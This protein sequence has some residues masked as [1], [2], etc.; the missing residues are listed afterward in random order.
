[1]RIEALEYDKPPTKNKDGKEISQDKQD[2]TKYIFVASVNWKE[3]GKNENGNSSSDNEKKDFF[4]LKG[5]ILGIS[6]G[7][8]DSENGENKAVQK[9]FQSALQAMNV[10]ALPPSVDVE[11]K[12]LEAEANNESEKLD[13]SAK[14]GPDSESNNGESSST[15]EPEEEKTT[16]K[17]E[18]E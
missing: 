15:S 12:Q 13:D 17:A 9:A 7:Y 10:T 8:T 5:L 4:K 3:D 18:S 1:M 2:S 16:S 11:A 14:K 6:S